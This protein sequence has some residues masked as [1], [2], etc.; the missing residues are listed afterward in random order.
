MSMQNLLKQAQQMQASIA[1]IEQELN[2]SIYFGTAGGNAVKVEMK[3]TCEIVNI[4][5]EESLLE[6]NSREMLQDMIMLAVNNAVQNAKADREE[7]MGAVTQGVK[8]PGIM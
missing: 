8:L 3:G 2:D 5:I 7:K 4:E 1:R 6:K